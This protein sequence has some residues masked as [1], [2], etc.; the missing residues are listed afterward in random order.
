[1]P[2]DTSAVIEVMT[3]PSYPWWP[4]T[5]Y[6]VGFSMFTVDSPRAD[7]TP[8]GTV[9]LPLF[10]RR[11]TRIQMWADPSHAGDETPVIKGR[12]MPPL[13]EGKISI[14]AVSVESSALTLGRW[15]SPSP[16]TVRLGRVTTDQ[17]GNFLLPSQG[18]PFPGRYAILARSEAH[19]SLASDWNCGPFFS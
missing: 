3:R 4:K 2:A 9:S 7:R 12:T 11:G 1:M 10:G 14:R 13:R 8:L 19:G 16:Y 18:F 17:H 6:E 5:R 15:E